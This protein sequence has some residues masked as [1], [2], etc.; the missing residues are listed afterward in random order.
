LENYVVLRLEERT[1]DFATPLHEALKF[2]SLAAE[3]SLNPENTP[4]IFWI[5]VHNPN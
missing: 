3:L 5:H 2:F 1:W 4:L